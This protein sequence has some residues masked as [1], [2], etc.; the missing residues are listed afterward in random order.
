MSKTEAHWG[1]RAALAVTFSALVAAGT[2]AS[3][4]DP[5][6]TALAVGRSGGGT[7][8]SA[9]TPPTTIPSPPST[10][11]THRADGCG[12]SLASG[13]PVSPVG[14][15][16]ILE[17]GDSLGNDLGWG[18]TRHLAA[19]TGLSLVQLDRSATGL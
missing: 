1:L 4:A 16:T 11:P 14:H 15:C 5:R 13:A 8:T 17:I 9:V 10:R 7:G 12:L 6:P 19:G 2:W 18:L 3:H